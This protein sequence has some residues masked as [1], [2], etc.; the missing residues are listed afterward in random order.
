MG[1]DKDLN[2][3]GVGRALAKV[4]APLTLGIFGVI[5]VGIA[6][7]FFLARLSEQALTATGFIYPVIITLTSLSIGLAAGTNKVTSQ[8]LGRHEQDAK[9][10]MAL[11]ALILAA[12]LSVAVGA[13]FYALAPWLFRAL[14]A[15]G[16]VHELVMDYVLWWTLSFPLLVLAQAT[17][18]IFRAGGRTGI[19][20]AVMVTQAV[21]NVG[22]TPLLIFGW[23]FVPQ[24][25]VAGAG[26]AT[27]A[28]RAL[29]LAA[30]LALGLRLG[31]VRPGAG[32]LRGLA[33]SARKIG[34]VAGPAALSNAINPAGMAAVTAAVAV[35]GDTA[36][37]GFGAATRVQQLLYVPMLAL[38]AG[39]G[40]VV[41]QAWGA[42]AGARAR[43]AV[44]L[45]FLT[46]LGYGLALAVAMTLWA[47]TVAGWMTNGSA[48]AENAERYLRIVGWSFFGYGILITA[49]AAMN[50]R[51]RA[52][53][54]MSLSAARIGLVYIPFAWLGVTA[55]GYEGILFAAL[56][57]N[58]LAVWGALVA[59]RTTGLLALDWPGVRGPGRWLER[60]LPG[61]R[62]A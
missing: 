58:L 36:V 41:G 7:A 34:P 37:A 43:R 33:A 30:I 31:M 11:H 45:T 50:A 48:A 6:D 35:V 14:G 16:E 22:L 19:V 60:R 1:K 52:L 21:I 62:H 2:E 23:A 8:A 53:W 9:D 51:G 15:E 17:G 54:S 49:N 24:F 61:A 13:L 27:F 55:I 18:A 38:S 4:S 3:G 29:E 42:G 20:S 57:A 26:I 40:P 25:G 32:M 39:I 5:S 47:G 28:A 46:C 44:G 59:C 56:A 10:R 12:G